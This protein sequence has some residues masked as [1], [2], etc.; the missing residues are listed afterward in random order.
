MH[1]WT[2]LLSLVVMVFTCACGG[3]SEAKSPDYGGGY[4]GEAVATTGMTREESAPMMDSEGDSSVD[5][6][7]EAY[8]RD[9]LAQAGP[10]AAPEPPPPPAAPKPESPSEGGEVSQITGPLLI[11]TA[12]FVMAVFEVKKSLDEVEAVGRDL[13]GFLSRRDDRS[14][15]V[16]IP[17]AR[18]DEAVARVEKLGDVVSRDVSSEDVTDQFRDL[19][20]RLQ[21]ATAMRDRLEKLL[22]KADKVED[23]LNVE[24]ELGRVTQEIELMKGRLKYLKD[25]VSFSTLTVEFRP[26]G[27]EHVGPRPVRLPLP[28]LSDLGLN[29][30]MSL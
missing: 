21:N 22:A 27:A 2:R 18:F 5:L 14:I 7:D 13:G 1:P 29:R 19:V 20:I 12:S 16:R 3:A 23:A 30:L 11:F 6:D 25:R 17:A 10:V 24:R 26:Q 8:S 4:P 28:W 9:F 15:T